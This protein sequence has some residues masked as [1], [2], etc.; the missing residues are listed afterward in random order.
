M[1]YE[2]QQEYIVHLSIRVRWT[3]ESIHSWHACTNIDTAWHVFLKKIVVETGLL[4]ASCHAYAEES[5]CNATTT[6]SEQTHA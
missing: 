4:I 6:A 1:C 3:H 5:Y 2:L